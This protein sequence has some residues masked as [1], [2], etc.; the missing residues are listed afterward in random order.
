MKEANVNSADIAAQPGRPLSATY[1]AGRREGER[2]DAWE[3]RLR[4]EAYRNQARRHLD[5]AA[6]ALAKAAELT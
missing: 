6:K 1:W 5:L 4:A 3:R 2:F